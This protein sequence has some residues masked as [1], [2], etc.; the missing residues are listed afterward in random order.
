MMGRGMTASPSFLL[1]S[2]RE[3]SIAL[4]QSLNYP[5]LFNSTIWLDAQ[6]ASADPYLTIHW[7][8]DS[9]QQACALVNQDG[10]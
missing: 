4:Y 7:P 9:Q 6:P 10:F 1:P 3:N 8:R 5:V 2:V